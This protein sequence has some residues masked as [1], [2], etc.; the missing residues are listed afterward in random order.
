MQGAT[1]KSLSEVMKISFGYKRKAG[2][3]E[4]QRPWEIPEE[5][6]YELNVL[7]LLHALQT[8]REWSTDNST[9]ILS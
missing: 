1:E 6:L 3:W 8:W 2:I 5:K 7:G 9:Q 4:K